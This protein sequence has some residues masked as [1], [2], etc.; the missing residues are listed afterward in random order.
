M[1][2]ALLFF[3]GTAY[4]QADASAIAAYRTYFDVVP[5]PMAAPAVVEVPFGDA[6]SWRSGMA[7]QDMTTQAFQPFFLKDAFARPASLSAQASLYPMDGSR[8]G[9]ILMVGA[10]DGDMD[11]YAEFPLPASEQGRAVIVVRAAAPITASQLVLSLD[12][13]VA[14]PNTISISANGKIVLATSRMGG[15]AVYFPQTTAKEW[16][17]NL[18]YG[19]PLR[20]TDMRFTERS[21]PDTNA[22]AIRFLAQ[23]NHTYRIYYNPD[24]SV[25]MPVG[26]AGNLS[27]DRD[28][29]RVAAGS[30][31]ENPAYVMADS[32]GDGVPDSNDNCVSVANADQADISGNGRGDA[33]DDF[34]K[35]GAVNSMDNCP[36]DPNRDQA[37][38][39][40]D[41][42]GDVCDG[43]ES[44]FTEKYPWLPWLGIGSAGLVLIAL[45]GLMAWSMRKD[46]V[47]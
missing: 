26:E 29:V 19:Q 22:R 17:I 47:A 32:D 37:D 40:A 46:G 27:A 23:P 41:G 13:H 34:D 45:F 12:D 7:V 18:T 30:S 16:N 31:H 42:K 6:A 14:L 5:A 21:V 24:R 35:D 38:T 44:R 36:N 28:V 33:C 20:I 10:I 9:D 2:P 25:V 1:I 39:D 8:G 4:A 15:Q 3:I 11:S 43:E